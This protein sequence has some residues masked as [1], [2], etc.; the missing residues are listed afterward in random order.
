MKWSTKKSTKKVKEKTL[1]IKDKD[2]FGS[3][4]CIAKETLW[5]RS[6][7]VDHLAYKYWC[8][9]QG[10]GIIKMIKKECGP[11]LIKLQA[12]YTER[13]IWDY[14]THARYLSGPDRYMYQIYQLVGG[15]MY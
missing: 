12:L 4:D 2:Q 6:E 13:C 8:V 15:I 7:K 1:R 5:K 10:S 11:V 9:L 14:A 3:W